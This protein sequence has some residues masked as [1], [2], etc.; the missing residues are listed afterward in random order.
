MQYPPQR[1]FAV[2]KMA[3]P[4]PNNRR[5]N[6]DQKKILKQK[7]NMFSFKRRKW[8]NATDIKVMCKVCVYDHE[9]SNTSDVHNLDEKSSTSSSSVPSF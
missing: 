4:K 7:Q 3:R 2:Y 5:Y 8:H 6:F 9:K 1:V